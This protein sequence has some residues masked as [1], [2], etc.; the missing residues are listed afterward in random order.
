MEAPIV[1]TRLVSG[2]ER[3]GQ[4][5]NGWQKCLNKMTGRAGMAE[6]LRALLHILA[7]PGNIK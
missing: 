4:D 6:T 3:G 1:F 7:N 5:V 2:N